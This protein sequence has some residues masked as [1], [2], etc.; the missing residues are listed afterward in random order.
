MSSHAHE[1]ALTVYSSTVSFS[2]EDKGI[3]QCVFFPPKLSW[4]CVNA[5]RL[6]FSS[7]RRWQCLCV[8]LDLF[9]V[10]VTTLGRLISS[11]PSK[12]LCFGGFLDFFVPG[13]EEPS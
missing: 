2:G 12:R 5:R 11:E 9:V 1:K 13:E 8:S 3:L 7:R 4:K 10:G 6:K